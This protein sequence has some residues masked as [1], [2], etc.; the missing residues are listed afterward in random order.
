MSIEVIIG[1]IAIL[2]AIATYKQ[3][4]KTQEIKFP[5]PI[6]E[7]N[8]LKAHFR[9]NQ[10]LSIEIQ[11]MLEKYINENQA[12]K[13]I[14]F[15]NMTFSKYLDYVKSEHESCLSENVYETIS[16]PIYTRSNIESMLASLQNQNTNLLMVRNLL[17]TLA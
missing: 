13:E 15:E 10:K 14:F 4:Q 2:I 3:G 17:K 9:M 1:I 7:M 11:N 16:E 12:A 5:K 6:E 8:N